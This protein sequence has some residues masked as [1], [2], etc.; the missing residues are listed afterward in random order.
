M[1]LYCEICDKHFQSRQGLWSHK[2]RHDLSRKVI[3]S[4]KKG[5]EPSKEVFNKILKPS[6][7]KKLKII[8][9]P[10]F[11][12]TGESSKESKKKLTGYESNTE[13]ES[14]SSDSDTSDIDWSK[15]IKKINDL[16]EKYDDDIMET[17]EILLNIIEKLIRKKFISAEEY[18][19][20]KPKLQ[21]KIFE[22]KYRRGP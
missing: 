18:V 1:T 9:A 6:S 20:W 11:C 12:K 13:S 22:M 4:S 5:R 10:I 7:F 17:Y 2:K 8:Q 14:E 15:L 19:L 3:G 21:K 16:A